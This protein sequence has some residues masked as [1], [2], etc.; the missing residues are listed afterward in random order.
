MIRNRSRR[1]PPGGQN[2][3]RNVHRKPVSRSGRV[4]RPCGRKHPPIRRRRGTTPLP[5]GACAYPRDS[6]PKA[7]SHLRF[8]L[9]L[10][11]V[12]SPCKGTKKG[13][14]FRRGPKFRFTVFDLH[15][16][17]STEFYS[18]V[19]PQHPGQFGFGH[20]PINYRRGT[21]RS[22]S[23]RGCRP[24]WEQTSQRRHRR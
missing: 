10:P 18:S 17:R 14:G 13:P 5:A 3:I 9:I 16:A 2:R 7:S 22:R 12:T 1:S 24:E 15:G 19:D 23:E 4:C 8:S 11:Q 21:G 6:H 20:C